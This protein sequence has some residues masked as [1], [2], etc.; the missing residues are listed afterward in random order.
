MKADVVL[1]FLRLEQST[2]TETE[3]VIEDLRTQLAERNGAV[4]ELQDRIQSTEQKLAELEKLI[5]QA[6]ES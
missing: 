6:L 1:W 4:Q 2:P 5:K 3:K